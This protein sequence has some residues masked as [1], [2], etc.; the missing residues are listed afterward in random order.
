MTWIQGNQ[1]K[2]LAKWHYA[3]ARIFTGH[4]YRDGVNNIP[5][6]DY[7]YLANTLDLKELKSDDI[8]Y[9]HTFYADQLFE[10]L[11]KL[12]YQQFTVVTHNA[13]TNV[14]FPPP[15]NVYWFTTNVAI[16]YKSIRSIPIGVEND[17]WLKD[18]K[19]IMEGKLGNPK[20]YKNL[21]YVNHN[22][23]TNPKKRQRPYDVL[24]GEKFA[25]IHIGSNGQGFENYIDNVYNHPFVV[26]PEGN[27]IDTHRIWE[28]LYMNTIPVCLKNI[29]LE[30]YSDLPIL[31]LNDWDEMNE[32]LL[33][34]TFMDMSHKEWN[35]DKLTFEYWKREICGK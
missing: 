30:F 20:K 31:V 5:Y 33:Y 11:G 25:T 13:D 23:S 17:F 28:C 6:G 3:P 26:C 15:D 19:R 2:T 29:N 14:D 24:K 1:F 27:G 22:I 16:R 35:T 18:K 8:I 34:D 12:E 4:S 10:K 9:T 32:K 7:R 21:V